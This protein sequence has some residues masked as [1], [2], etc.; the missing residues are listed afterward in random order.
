[1]HPSTDLMGFLFKTLVGQRRVSSH[2][3]A[4][5]EVLE[6]SSTVGT[7]A[8]GQ[9]GNG[10]SI[11]CHNIAVGGTGN[12]VGQSLI[13]LPFERL[14]I[15]TSHESAQHNNNGPVVLGDQHNHYSSQKSTHSMV[16]PAQK[17]HNH[18]TAN[19]LHSGPLRGTSPFMLTSPYQALS[20]L[21]T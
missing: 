10:G 18:P 9:G 15:I 2:R 21:Q 16:H 19:D 5:A 17:F 20:K 12:H 11:G 6:P 13:H 14:L 1:V 3:S 4:D 8:G 7:G